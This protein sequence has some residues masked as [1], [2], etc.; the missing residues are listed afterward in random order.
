MTRE[1]LVER[2]P[3]ETLAARAPG[4]PL[5]PEPPNQPIEPPQTAVV[6]RSSVVLVVAPK[7]GI[8]RRGLVRDQVVPML[9][10]PLPP[11]SHSAEGV[12]ERSG[13]ES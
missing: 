8:E 7:F 2:V 9:L 11:P 13:R 12:C 4:Q 3:V 6:R 5:V 1:Q 10:A